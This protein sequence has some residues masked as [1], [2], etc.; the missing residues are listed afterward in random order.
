M[1]VFLYRAELTYN[2]NIL[3]LVLKPDKNILY[4]NCM[5]FFLWIKIS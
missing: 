1:P 4:A 2:L 5:L 3:S